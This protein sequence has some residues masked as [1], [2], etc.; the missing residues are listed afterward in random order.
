MT[1]WALKEALEAQAF[2]EKA[3]QPGEYEDVNDIRD[4]MRILLESKVESASSAPAVSQN[5][6][7]NDACSE[8]EEALRSKM[9][10]PSQ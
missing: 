10:D 9:K 4:K 8:S 7:G 6:T 5:S 3:E 1:F 2:P